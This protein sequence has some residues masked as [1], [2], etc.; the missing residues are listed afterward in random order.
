MIIPLVSSNFS[1]FAFSLK[2]KHTLTLREEVWIHQNTLTLPLFIEM[3]VPCKEGVKEEV[4]Y[5]CALHVKLFRTF[6]GSHLDF[7]NQCPRLPRIFRFSQSKSNLAFLIHDFPL[8]LYNSNT[9]DATSGPYIVV[10]P[11]APDF[12]F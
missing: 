5:L 6:Y 10:P 4:M 2:V 3:P 8:D 11:G 12:I 7:V 9:A 1:F